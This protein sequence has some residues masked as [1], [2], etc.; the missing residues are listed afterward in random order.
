VAESFES[1]KL[2]KYILKLASSWN[3][4]PD[5]DLWRWMFDHWTP[6]TTKDVRT[7]IAD[8]TFLLGR[9]TAERSASQPKPRRVEPNQCSTPYCPGTSRHTFESKRLCSPCLCR[10]AD[11]RSTTPEELLP[12]FDEDRYGPTV[13]ELP[14]ALRTPLNGLRAKP[15]HAIKEA[16]KA[17]PH[18]RN[19]TH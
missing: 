9:A 19:G 15:C 17:G 1:G 7:G 6:G 3:S 8:L 4:Y 12:S 16:R 11:E 18:L 5:A 2:F 13:E 14:S 10:I